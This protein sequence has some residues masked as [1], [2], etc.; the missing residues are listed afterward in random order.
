[1]HVCLYL[2]PKATGQDLVDT[3]CKYI[4]LLE[5]DYFGLEYLD[6]GHNVVSFAPV[7]SGEGSSRSL[8]VLVGSRQTDSQTSH[9]NEVLLLCEILHTRSGTVGRGIH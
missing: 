1:M 3:V 8:A 6:V 2:Q 5:K 4:E 9:G 7:A